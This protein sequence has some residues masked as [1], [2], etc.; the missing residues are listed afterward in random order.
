MPELNITDDLLH[1]L[2]IVAEKDYEGASIDQTLDRL[3]REHQEFVMLEAA[4]ALERNA[5]KQS[6]HNY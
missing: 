5:A 2:Q 6:G 3:L 4:A 1:R